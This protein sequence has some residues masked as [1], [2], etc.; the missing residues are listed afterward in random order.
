MLSVQ[1]ALLMKAVQDEIE[2]EEAMQLGGAVGGVGGALMGAAGGSIPLAMGNAL[3]NLKDKAAASRG[4]T[5]VRKTMTR[6]RPG[7]RMAGGLTGL[8][9]GGG[10]GA[11]MAAIMKKESE[12]GRILGKI[13]AQGGK[14]DANDELK[15]SS[16]LGDLYQN[17]SQ[18]M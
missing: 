15:L 3:N 7:P 17:P 4:L 6:L 18:L 16:I 9:L 14:L 12:A 1:E 11:G 2:A 5:P 10:L 8:I 13:Q